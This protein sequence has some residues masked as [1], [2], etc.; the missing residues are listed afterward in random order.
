MR[1]QVKIKNIR[2]EAIIDMGA[3]MSIISKKLMDRLKL[4]IDEKSIM[5]IV[6]ITGIRTRAL[7]N[8]NNLKISIQGMLIPTPVQV[9]D[10]KNEILILENNWFEK[11][12]ARIYIDEQKLVLKYEGQKIKV[13]ITNDR[14]R[15]VPANETDDDKQ[16]NKEQADKLLDEI[17]YKE[18]KVKEKKVYY[19]EESRSDSDSNDD[20]QS[21]SYSDSGSN[22]ETRSEGSSPAMYFTQIGESLPLEE[23]KL[24]KEVNIEK[25]NKTSIITEEIQ[26]EVPE[27]SSYIENEQIVKS[28]INIDTGMLEEDA[29]AL[30]EEL[31][32]PMELTQEEDIEEK[33]EK[34]EMDDEFAAEQVEQIKDILKQGHDVF[35]QSY[36]TTLPET[37]EGDK[38]K[39]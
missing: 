14:A 38:G 30:I 20:M 5:T 32:M 33:I 1:Y 6:S 35:A 26:T 28:A 3:V 23:E 21:E 2:V 12:K 31:L 37:K 16:Y 9:V 25:G 4:K 19:T 17:V 8:I 27:E 36:H 15:K 13:S 39:E 7:G 24:S 34:L 29:M 18:K 11:I 10:F 22:N